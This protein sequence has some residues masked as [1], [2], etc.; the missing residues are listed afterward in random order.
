MKRGH[1]S[2]GK[3]FAML[4]RE[5][6]THC[7][8]TTLEHAGFRVLVLLAAEYRG[9]NNGAIGVTR[10]QA[11]AHAG[12]SKNTLYDALKVLKA[13][14]LIELTFPGSKVPPS[15]AMYALNWLPLNDTE[16]TIKT[17]V[18]SHE[19]R[20]W[21]LPKNNI[22]GSTIGNNCPNHW[23]QGNQNPGLDPNHWDH[24][25]QNLTSPFPL[26]GSPLISSHRQGGCVECQSRLVRTSIARRSWSCA[27]EA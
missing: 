9:S 2:S 15:P 7:S 14:G 21:T 16:H 19:Y 20:N 6:L 26:R 24:G 3:R 5:L 13:R 8:V 27:T 12:L 18:A 1:K 4:P 22:R 10:D 23:E 17:R 11:K 25:C